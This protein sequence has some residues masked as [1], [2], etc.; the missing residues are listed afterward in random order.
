ME[1]FKSYK[2][3]HLINGNE[4]F[5]CQL[6]QKQ[7]GPAKWFIFPENITS[8]LVLYIA[9]ITNCRALLGIQ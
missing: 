8:E 1:L 4:A 7:L 6:N 5:L 3:N 9:M 2:E